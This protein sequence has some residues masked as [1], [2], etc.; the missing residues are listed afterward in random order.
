MLTTVA[1]PVLDELAVFEFG[2][3][4]EVFGGRRNDPEIPDFEL[5]VC[6][7]QA[8][9]PLTTG[10]GAH[11]TP[12]LDLSA[13]NDA[14]L[15]AVPAASLRHDYPEELLEALRTASSQGKTIL[16]ICSGAFILGAAGLLDGR[17]CS[18]HWKYIDDLQRRHPTANVLEDVLYVDDGNVITSA[19]TAAGVDACLH[20]VRKELGVGVANALAR[21][22]VVSAHRDGGQRQFIE[23][24]VPHDA[25]DGVARVMEHMTAQLDQPHSIE[26]LASYA[27]LSRRSFTRRFLQETGTTPMRWL[28]EQRLLA[29]R[30]LLEETELNVETI[31]RDCGFGSAA[32]MRKRFRAA[33]D[34]A[35]TAYR[36][37]A[38]ATMAS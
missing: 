34:T 3:I 29:A 10:A 27:H 6:G 37:V 23:R 25:N 26:D 32:I 36:S 24:P 18:T 9:K 31:A 8:G 7:V 21:Q 38:K 35:P 15:I 19:G 14:D 2:V 17:D 12:L 30:H 13:F 5:R 16:S 4:C 22:M 33:F 1:V 20:V 11:I 28:T